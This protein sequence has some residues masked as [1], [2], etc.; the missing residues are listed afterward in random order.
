MRCFPGADVGVLAA[1]VRGGVPLG[2]RP[3]GL[4]Q[5]QSDVR[6]G[7]LW[8][9]AVSKNDEFCIQNK[10][11]CINNE[12]LCIKTKEFCSKH[13]ECLQSGRVTI[14]GREWIGSAA[15]G[16]AFGYHTPQ[17]RVPAAAVALRGGT[18]DGAGAHDVGAAPRTD[19]PLPGGTC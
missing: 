9:T 5:C 14:R 12:E 1:G 8:G 19:Q 7:R 15:D 16:A 6:G 2:R 4:D 10:E 17:P 11:L 13:D 3:D 18:A